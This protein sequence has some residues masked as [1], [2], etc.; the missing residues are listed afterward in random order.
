MQNNTWKEWLVF[1]KRDRNA[2]I[3]LLS[4][5]S[6]V[7]LL[8]YFL[9]AKKLEINIDRNLQQQLDAY[10]QEN[11]SEKSTSYISAVDTIVNDT[12]KKAL[13]FFDPNTLNEDGFEKIGLPQKAI[14][15]LINYRNKG[16]YFKT[17]EDIRKIYGLSKSDADRLIPYV[18][19]AASNKNEK[20]EIKKYEQPNAAQLHQYKKININTATVEDWKAFPGIGDILAARILKFKTSIGGFKSVEQVGKTYGLSD[21]VFQSIKPYLLLKDSSATNP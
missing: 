4:I 5:L 18:R 11:V 7:I 21:S 13:F 12:A 14:H 10:K 3:I 1:T 20:P 6:S 2:A 16:G 19:I 15:T 8:P 9:P 17:A